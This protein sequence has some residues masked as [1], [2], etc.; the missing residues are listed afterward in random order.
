MGEQR[1]TVEITQMDAEARRWADVIVT[2]PFQGS[3]GVWQVVPDGDGCRVQLSMKMRAVGPWRPL[4]PLVDR[5]AP[6]DLRAEL[7]NLKRVLEA[8]A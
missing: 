7:A 4:A 8:R 1:F 3:T 5:I 2:G 6:R